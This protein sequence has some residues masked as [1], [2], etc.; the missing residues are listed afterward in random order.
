M[1]IELRNHAPTLPGLKKPLLRRTSGG[2]GAAISVPAAFGGN[3]CPK[4]SF[5]GLTFH[6]VEGV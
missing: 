3:I 1:A 5:R 6:L 2:G 4:L